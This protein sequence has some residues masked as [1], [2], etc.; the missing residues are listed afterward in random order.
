[1]PDSGD[2]GGLLEKYIVFKF[3]AHFIG[4]SLFQEVLIEPSIQNQVERRNIASTALQDMQGW[5]IFHI[6]FWPVG[7]DFT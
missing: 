6:E 7:L 3:L 1:M 4:A 5:Q 2:I